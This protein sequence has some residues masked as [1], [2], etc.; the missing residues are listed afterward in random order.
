[1][2]K[3]LIGKEGSGF[4]SIRVTGRTRDPDWITAEIEIRAGVW[5]GKYGG[6]L[7][8]G[9]LSTLADNLQLIY[10]TLSGTA[11][12]E[13]LDGF[14]RLTFT[15]DGKGHVSVDGKAQSETS[16]NNVLLLSIELDQTDLPEVIDGLRACESICSAKIPTI[17]Q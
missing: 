16:V 5:R 6:S 11:C 15:G 17:P 3:V 9:E 12:L 8:H 10:A 2:P 13:C 7:Y 1:M 4:V 14:L